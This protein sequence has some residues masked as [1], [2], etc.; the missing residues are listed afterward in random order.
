MEICHTC[1][2]C[3]KIDTIDLADLL[4]LL[5]KHNLFEHQ[6]KMVIKI[7]NTQ[8]IEEKIVQRVMDVLKTEIQHSYHHIAMERLHEWVMKQSDTYAK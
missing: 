1:D 2:S 4:R 7:M 5:V 8:E 6:E 3:G